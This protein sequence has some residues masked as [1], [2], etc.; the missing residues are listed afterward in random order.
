MK[1]N[2]V[3]F[4]NIIDKYRSMGKGNVRLTQSSLF[5]VK[6]ITN[7]STTYNFDVLESVNG[8]VL[9]EEI[10]LNIN[11]EFI[12]TELGIYLYGTQNVEG[13][14]ASTGKRLFTNTLSQINAAQANNVSPVY[15]G[16]LKIAVNNI[17]YVEKWDSKKHEFVPRTQFQPFTN[18]VFPA[19]QD[20]NDWMNDGMQEL[21]PMV[22]LSGAKKTELS[23][24]LPTAPVTA[25]FVTQ[26]NAGQIVTY[27]I[28]KIAILLRGLNAQNA[29]R[30]Q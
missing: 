6:D 14:P 12:V 20:S 22:T 2:R 5:L 10:R 26:D 18:G 4:Q 17:V 16:Q 11:D 29:S 25:S 13:N 27:N 30:F 3:N 9:P 24:T 1:L 19:L 15:Q 8:N 7:T 28:N 21:A 23:L